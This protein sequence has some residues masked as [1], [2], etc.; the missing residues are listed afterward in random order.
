MFRASPPMQ[1]V[2][3]SLT[4]FAAGFLCRSHCGL[5]CSAKL[6]TLEKA[7]KLSVQVHSANLHDL[8]HRVVKTARP[9]VRVAVGDRVKETEQGDWSGELGA[10]RF[11]ECITLEVSAQDNILVS[12]SSAMRY[13][14][15]V[16][17]ISTASRC[18]GTLSLPVASVLHRLRWEDRDADGMFY[19]SPVLGFDV[20]HEGRFHG[21]L[22][23]S[24]EMQSA[25][26]RHATADEDF[27]GGCGLQEFN[28]KAPHLA[29]FE[30]TSEWM[31]G[32]LDSRGSSAP[33]GGRGGVVAASG[34]G[35]Q[36]RPRAATVALPLAPPALGGDEPHM[37][38]WKECP[39]K[40]VDAHGRRPPSPPPLSPPMPV[41]AQTPREAASYT[42]AATPTGDSADK[43]FA[44]GGGDT[45]VVLGMP[46]RSRSVHAPHGRAGCADI[47]RTRE[48]NGRG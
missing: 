14:F 39:A 48:T 42:T 9:F 17:T 11:G 43:G 13:E 34:R 45:A 28:A 41:W 24:F 47:F 22:R 32:S 19:A 35:R 29:A 33:G 5:P 3:P 2:L 38:W 46:G 6:G 23:L 8:D 12:V 36:G 26:P 16:A 21:C 30:S 25:P 37:D 1:S 7:F 31:P 40:A 27:C 44:H 15:Y 18:L 10:W 4:T 20:V